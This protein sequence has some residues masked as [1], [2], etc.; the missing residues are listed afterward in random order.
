[1]PLDRPEDEDGTGDK[2]RVHILRQ[3]S[4]QGKSAEFEANAYTQI[5]ILGDFALLGQWTVIYS[6]PNCGKTL[7]TTAEVVRSIK[8]GI[9][10]PANLYYINAD[11]DYSGLTTKLKLAE[12]YGFHMLAP[13]HNGFESKM[14]PDMLKAL[15]DCGDAAGII[16]IIDTLKKFTETND[17]KQASAFGRTVRDFISKGGTLI[18]LSHTNKNPGT[19]GK[20]KF[21]GT[22]DIVDDADCVYTLQTLDEANDVRTIEFSNIKARGN[23][24]NTATYQYSI[25]PNHGYREKLASVTHVKP[26]EVAALKE[27]IEADKSGDTALI[28]IVKACISKGVNTKTTLCD[29]VAERGNV[30]KR[31]AAELIEKYTGTDPIRHHWNYKVGNR[32]VQTF[33]LLSLTSPD[34]TPPQSDEPEDS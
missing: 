23:V 13:G 1:M 3:Y 6:A 30:G 34:P 12:E 11:D 4:L 21:G 8:S 17:K 33:S 15:G 27:T 2:D 9:I 16:I 18:A 7:V 24:T 29:E 26:L 14:L 22:S 10:N 5:K 25:A 32:G 28:E 31:R 19:D 20:P